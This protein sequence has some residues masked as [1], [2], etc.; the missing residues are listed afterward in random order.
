MSSLLPGQRSVLPSHTRSN[1]CA[2]CSALSAMQILLTVKI[3]LFALL[4]ALNIMTHFPDHAARSPCHYI[5]CT[6]A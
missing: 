4:Q 1:R 5:L 2:L 3:R 6:I